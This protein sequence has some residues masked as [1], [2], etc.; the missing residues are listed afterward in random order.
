MI[1][2]LDDIYKVNATTK[3]QRRAAVFG[4]FAYYTEVVFKCGVVLYFA[5]MIAY[6]F[7]PFCMYLL[8]G[9][10][11]TLIPTYLPGIDEHTTNGYIIVSCY[12]ILILFL[13]FV[14]LS[15]SDLLFTMLIANTPIMSNMIAL[16]VKR[17]NDML[18]SPKIDGL[19]MK[20]TFR[21]LLL[22]HREM[23]ELSF[24]SQSSKWNFFLIV[25][26]HSRNRFITTMDRTFFKICFAQISGAAL[27][28]CVAFFVIL[29][30]RMCSNGCR[31]L[32]RTLK[33]TL[34]PAFQYDGFYFPVYMLLIALF[35]QIISFCALGTIIELAVI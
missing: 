24:Y 15:S 10:I 32:W 14:G 8:N 6:F 31:M 20:C 30:V 12:H 11:V 13:S 7:Y 5:S 19:L 29:K 2:Y 35:F 9:E 21:N 18:T 17:L 22:M 25:S 34:I 4:R 27:A 3:N 33:N 26:K 28:S 23:T 1:N 16:E